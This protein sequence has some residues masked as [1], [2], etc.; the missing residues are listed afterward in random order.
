MNKNEIITQL[1][2]DNYKK[3]YKFALKLTKAN[4]MEANEIISIAS[5]RLVKHFDKLEDHLNFNAWFKTIIFNVFLKYSKNKYKTIFFEDMRT[6]K[7]VDDGEQTIYDFYL[8]YELSIEQ[9]L[10]NHK[11]QDDLYLQI[12]LLPKMQ[13]KVIKYMVFKDLTVPEVARKLNL[14]YETTKTHYRT[15]MLNLQKNMINLK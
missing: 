7:D 15:G 8:N 14:N 2:K 9:D 10:T 11:K 12:G 6:N 1:W 13:Q 4:E 5:L 3:F